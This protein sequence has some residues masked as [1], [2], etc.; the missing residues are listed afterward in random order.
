MTLAR[1]AALLGLSKTTVSRALAGYDDVSPATRERVRAA[2]E[3]F[4]YIPN[5]WARVLRSGKTAQVG[6]VAP[7]TCGGL[8]SPFVLDLLISASQALG[9]RDFTLLLASAPPGEEELAALRRMVEGHRVDAV[10][11]VQT[12]RR[13]PRIAY[14]LEQGTTFVCH[15][16]TEEERPYAFVDLDG[17][18][19]F[20][21]ACERLI[22]LGHARI[23]YVGS[24][25][26]TYMYAAHRRAGYEAAL[27]AAG[28]A[29]AEDLI[30]EGEG[31]EDLG[32]RAVAQLLRHRPPPTALL[33]ATDL[34][35]VGALQAA[36]AVGLRV[37]H[38]LSIIGHDDL[39]LSRYTDPPLTTVGQAYATIG[40]RLCEMLFAL[41]AGTPAADVQEVWMPEL[42]LRASDGPPPPRRGD[43]SPA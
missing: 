17:E 41:L 2:A 23:A 19:A 10:I 1:L 22:G 31:G 11:V 8:N 26:S 33:C 13:D 40:V 36:A 28:L 20:R 25:S 39:P 30:V 32:R 7:S 15:G 21:A 12:R 27:N 14:L 6:V 37:G 24:F 4:G 38:D 43:G 16:R 18:A 3:A 34:E 5:P 35:A 29:V 42:I 9:E